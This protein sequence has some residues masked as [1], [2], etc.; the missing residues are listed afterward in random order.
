MAIPRNAP[1]PVAA[2]YFLNYLLDFKP[3]MDNFSWVGYQPPQNRA[4]PD[5]LTSTEGRYSKISNW[6]EPAQYVLPWMERAVVRKED[7]EVGY[8]LA[9]LSPEVDALWHDAWQEFKAGV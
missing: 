7:F 1:H 6:A 9:E 2:H 5:T 4:D 3:A 8:R